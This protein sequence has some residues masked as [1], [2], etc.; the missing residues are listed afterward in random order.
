[1]SFCRLVALLKPH[2]NFLILNNLSIRI[3]QHTLLNLFFACQKDTNTHLTQIILCIN[4]EIY[5]IYDTIRT[6]NMCTYMYTYHHN[7]KERNI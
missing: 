2:R 3:D 6:Y 7:I 1:M 5:R 4:K